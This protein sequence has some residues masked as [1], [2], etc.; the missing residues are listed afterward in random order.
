MVIYKK[1]NNIEIFNNTYWESNVYTLK[2]YLK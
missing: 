1:A 2:I